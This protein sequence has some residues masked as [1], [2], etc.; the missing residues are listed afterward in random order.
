[1][2]NGKFTIPQ[3]KDIRTKRN[4]GTPTDELADKYDC[5]PN[6]IRSICRGE[7]YASVG[8]PTHEGHGNMKL[9]DDEIAEIRQRYAT[10]NVSQRDLAL[11]YEVSHATIGKVINQE[12]AYADR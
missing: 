1:M 6:T 9:T 12:G 2:N 3:V 10:E 8:G 11:T 7:S 4:Q 5:H